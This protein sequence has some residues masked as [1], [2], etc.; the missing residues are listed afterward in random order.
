MECWCSLQME[1][2]CS[3]ASGCCHRGFREGP[4]D[5]KLQVSLVTLWVC[6]G[7]LAGQQAT[8]GWIWFDIRI[9]FLIFE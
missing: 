7:K 8:C 3:L 4:G 6:G 5:T 2:L 1:A 9:S